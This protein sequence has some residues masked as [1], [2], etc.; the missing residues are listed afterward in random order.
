MR[1][2]FL[3]RDGVINENRQDYVRRPEDFCFLNG[4][5]DAL[6]ALNTSSFA[7]VVVTN[8]SVVGRGYMTARG[9]QDVHTLMLDHVRAAGGRIDAIYVCPHHPADRCGCRKP[10]TDLLRRAATDLGLDL[11]ASYFVGDAASDVQ[12]ARAVGCRPILVLTGRGRQA[13]A[14][15]ARSG[16]TGYQQVEDLPAAVATVL[17][18]EQ[19]THPDGTWAVWR[20]DGV[21]ELGARR[22]VGRHRLG[23]PTRA[24]AAAAQSR[25]VASTWRF[26]NGCEQ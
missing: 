21:G 2:L 13:R 7:V 4:T 24:G 19:D 23:V 9:L 10:G 22:A 11:A 26:E 6:A 15:L 25:H 20:P 3:D 16:I 1:A 12:A 8:Q 5:L 18:A 17:A 14:E